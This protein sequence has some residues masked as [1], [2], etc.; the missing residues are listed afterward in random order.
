MNSSYKS[1]NMRRRATILTGM[2]CLTT[3]LT[4]RTAFQNFLLICSACR[5]SVFS[6]ISSFGLDSAQ[7]L[8]TRPHTAQVTG[9]ISAA[10]DG[11]FLSNWVLLKTLEISRLAQNNTKHHVLYVRVQHKTGTE[12]TVCEVILLHLQSPQHRR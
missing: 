2:Q 9:H 11:Q 8:N 12:Q 3:S 10:K 7:L 5:F 6:A 1:C 4:L